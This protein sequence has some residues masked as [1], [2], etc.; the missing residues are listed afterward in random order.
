MSMVER[1]HQIAA[2]H[3][4]NRVTRQRQS[5]K[6]QQSHSCTR[7]RSSNSTSPQSADKQPKS[8]T[9]QNRRYHQLDLVHQPQFQKALAQHS[10]AHHPHVSISGY[11]ELHIGNSFRSRSRSTLFFADIGSTPRHHHHRSIAMR[12]TP[13]PAHVHTCANP[14]HNNRWF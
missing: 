3:P 12:P 11:P 2:Q 9:Q 13:V 7:Q 4:T 8:V 10:P 6:A 14:S 1:P 5:T